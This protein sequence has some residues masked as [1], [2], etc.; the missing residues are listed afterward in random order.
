MPMDVFE[1]IM[2]NYDGDT[3]IINGI[4]KQPYYA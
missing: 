1:F 2:E 3:D 4:Y